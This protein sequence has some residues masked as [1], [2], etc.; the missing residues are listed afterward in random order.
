M[1]KKPTK[2]E[3]HDHSH[4]VNRFAVIPTADRLNAD[5]R[6][7][8]R[9]VTIAFLDSGFQQHPDLVEP[10]NRVVAFHDISGEETEAHSARLI[11]SWHWHGTQTTV[12]AAGNGQL[13]DGKYRGLASDAQLVL[14]KV[15]QNGRISEE[16]IAKGLRWVI[17][18]RERFNIRVLNISLGGDEDVPCSLST[19]DQL[20]EEAIRQGVVVVVAAGNTTDHAPIPPANSPSVIT[21]GGYDDGNNLGQKDLDLYHSSFGVTA[22]GTV[23]PELIAPAMWVAA[24]ILPNT[25]AY[26]RAEALSKLAAAPDYQLRS[27]ARELEERAELPESIAVGD[28]TAIRNFVESNLERQKIVATH[29]QHVDGTSFAAPIVS[30]IVAQMLEANPKLTPGAVKNILISTAD[31]IAAAPAI[32]Q[33]YGVVNARRAVELALREEHELKTVGCSPPRVE[34]GRLVFLY[35]DDEAK[36]VSLVGDFNSWDTALTPLRKD[37]SGLWLA[38]VE[39]PKAGNYQY[40]F[41]VDGSRWLEDP[42]NGMKVPDNYG[43]LN[44]VLAID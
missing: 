4:G 23:K 18:N 44:S 29:Y 2:V 21:V 3:G 7:S 43:G 10:N 36:N 39:A 12:A 37:K 31:R 33:G 11:E 30:S 20:A 17:K 41:I 1:D 6:F 19:I 25:R 9:G 26:E 5:P 8:G 27:L 34:N 22:G 15:S 42:S 24:P 32:R 40:K 35:H 16:N 14:V 38:E 13:C 28:L